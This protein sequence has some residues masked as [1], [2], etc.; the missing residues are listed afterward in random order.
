MK[1]PHNFWFLV[2]LL[3]TTA[4]AQSFTINGTVRDSA[5]GELLVAANIRLD[6]TARGTIS[7]ADGVFRLALPPGPYTIIVSFIGYRPDTV[8]VNLTRDVHYDVSLAPIAIRFSEIVVTDEDPAYRIMRKVIENKSRWREGLGTYT[9]DAFTRQIL[10]RDTA[11]ASITESYTT[12]YWQRGDSLREVIRQKRQT[13]NIPM[14]QNFAAVGGIVNFYDDEIRFSGFTF[15]GP[16]SPEAFDYY[17]FSLVATRENDGVEYYSI[18]MTPRT[19]LTP[20]FSGT[21]TVVGESYALS[22]VE[23]VPNESYRIPFVT[24]LEVTYAQQFALYENAFWMPVDIRLKGSAEIGIA[25]FSLPRISF[26]Q[27]SSI[28]DYA[29]NVDVPDTLFQKPRRIVAPE[30]EQHDSVFWAE[31]E[32]LALTEEEERAYQTLDSTQTLQKQFQPSGPLTTLSGL[33]T[34]FLRYVD[35]RFNRAEGLFLGANIQRDS[36]K[37]GLSIGVKAGYGFSDRRAKVGGDIEWFLNAEQSVSVGLAFYSDIAHIP[38]EGFF[39]PLL[40][41]FSALFHKTD[42]RDYYYV[43]G[44]SLFMS[45]QPSPRFSLRAGFTDEIHRF[46]PKSSDYSFFFRSRHYRAQP[47]IAEGRFRAVTLRSRY[48]EAPVPLGLVS[49]TFAE[50][51]LEHSNRS[52]FA[53]DFHFTRATMIG[54]FSLPTFLKRNLFPPALLGRVSAGISSGSLPPQRAFFVQ[55][56]SVAFGPL[57]ILKGAG[58]REFGGDSF[59]HLSL[60]HNFRSIPFLALDFPLFYENSIELLIHGSLARSWKRPSTV[61]PFATTTHG[62]YTEAGLG[63]S[64]L[65]GFMRIDFTRRFSEPRGNVFTIAVAR[66]F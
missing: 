28:Y 61:L 33:G 31:K 59:V 65:F 24:K 10:R 16:T 53:S 50:L 49:R 62:W 40:I 36:L 20:L 7:N 60:E 25:G 15:V 37:H 45:A 29:L 30:A 58:L 11:I 55:G 27:V 35:F 6:G 42:Q 44:A 41:S 66:V 5:N 22:G 23:V 2:F 9:F 47:L 51:E 12:G 63:V 32:V 21:V 1:F 46:A 39:Q 43:R 48:G 18:R 54:E 34:G 64:R 17:F 14:S 57:G 26:E 38:D 56:S 3:P 13:E 19:K 4:G 8:I 52:V